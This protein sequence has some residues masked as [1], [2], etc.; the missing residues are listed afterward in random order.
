MSGF[1]GILKAPPSAYV[2]DKYGTEHCLVL[3]DV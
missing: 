3:Q 1:V 2:I